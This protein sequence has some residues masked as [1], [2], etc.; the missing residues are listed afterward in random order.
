MEIWLS[1]LT[2]IVKLNYKEIQSNFVWV[3]LLRKIFNYRFLE[4]SKLNEGLQQ[5][6]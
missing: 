4:H 3:Y 2:W 6:G 5:S 1:I